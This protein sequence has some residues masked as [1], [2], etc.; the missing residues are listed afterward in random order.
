ME[1]HGQFRST[2]RRELP[3]NFR[4][5]RL[6]SFGG[7]ECSRRKRAAGESALFG[8]AAAMARRQIFSASVFAAGGRKASPRQARTFA[9]EKITSAKY[10]PHSSS[11]ASSSSQPA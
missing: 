2:G 3:R 4:S 5:K 9:G 11:Q 10:C 1:S 6:G 8:F 7:R